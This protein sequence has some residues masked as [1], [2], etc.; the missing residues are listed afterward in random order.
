MTINQASVSRMT[1][2]RMLGFRVGTLVPDFSS[3]SHSKYTHLTQRLQHSHR[4]SMGQI[5]YW[6]DFTTLVDLLDFRGTYDYYLLFIQNVVAFGLLLVLNAC[7]MIWCRQ[8]CGNAC[9]LYLSLSLCTYTHT[10]IYVCV[11]VCVC[12]CVY[13]PNLMPYVLHVWPVLIWMINIWPIVAAS[14]TFFF[15]FYSSN[16]FNN[17]EEIK[18]IGVIVSS[19]KAS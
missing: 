3:I 17:L 18:I 8:C 6:Y 13:P 9:L 5:K 7:K 16:C 10:H 11:C 2:A 12:V 19:S 15:I 1:L 4:D 14:K